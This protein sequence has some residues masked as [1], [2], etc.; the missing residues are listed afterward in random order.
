[1][2]STKFVDI[3]EIYGNWLQR[4]HLVMLWYPRKVIKRLRIYTH[5]FTIW[6]LYLLFSPQVEWLAKERPRAARID[7][8][9][10]ALKNLHTD[11]AWP[12]PHCTLG[13]LTGAIPSIQRKT[14]HTSLSSLR[15][16]IRDWKRRRRKRRR[17]GKRRKKKA[18]RNDI[19]F[20]N[21]PC[22]KKVPR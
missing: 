2:I 22:E 14:S 15:L 16:D 3:I 17:R 4:R 20:K 5:K 11:F 21:I 19:S 6:F 13:A 7:N 8:F 12:Y 10:A 18:K 9:I 1:V